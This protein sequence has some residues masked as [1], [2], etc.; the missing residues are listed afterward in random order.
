MDNKSFQFQMNGNQYTFKQMLAQ[1]SFGQV[2]L[3]EDCA[4]NLLALKVIK[5]GQLKKYPQLHQYTQSEIDIMK[6]IKHPN[7]LELISSEKVGGT[8]NLLLEYCEEG[9]LNKHIFSLKKKQQLNM[10]RISQEFLEILDGFDMLHSNHIIHRDVKP[11]NILYKNGHPKISDFGFSKNIQEQDDIAKTIL[12]TKQTMAPELFENKRYTYSADIFGLGCILYYMIYQKYPF[13]AM[14][15]ELILQQ[16]KQKKIT[17]PESQSDL[18]V[19]DSIKQIIQRM[20]SYNPELR[21][22]I[23]EIRQVP[24]FKNIRNEDEQNIK[25][26]NKPRLPTQ[27]LEIVDCINKNLQEIQEQLQRQQ[28]I[29]DQKHIQNEKGEENQDGM[30]KNH[31]AIS[32][33]KFKYYQ[34]NIQNL[35]ECQKKIQKNDL[36]QEFYEQSFIYTADDKENMMIKCQIQEFK[37]YL[38]EYKQINQIS[39]MVDEVLQSLM[40]NFK[41]KYEEDIEYFAVLLYRYFFQI[42]K[43]I[44]DQLKSQEIKKYLNFDQNLLN[45]YQNY[46]EKLLLKKQSL[47]QSALQSEPS[48]LSQIEIEKAVQ[49]CQLFQ[50][51]YY[52]L[53]QQSKDKQDNQWFTFQLNLSMITFFLL[54]KIDLKNFDVSHYIETIS[55]LNQEDTSQF[56]CLFEQ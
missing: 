2:F 47:S 28:L 15:Q 36:L 11:D 10:E 42:E 17:F 39:Q 24:Y 46:E 43:S 27:T 50:N 20:L 19:D 51:A 1:G 55:S 6:Q 12:G 26:K 52:Q 41:S 8:Y 14:H 33:Q 7:I 45:E 30:E 21:P 5:I 4:Q 31:K 40:S 37:M 54:N 53:S 13:T 22:S 56:V 3:V 34:I 35:Q 25:N 38:L 49:F 23:D 44:Q 9:D 48:K 18:K 16:I 29:E 32:S